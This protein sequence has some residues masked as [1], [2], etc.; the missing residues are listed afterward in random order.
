MPEYLAPGVYV[1]EIETRP[2][3]IPGV[4][5]SLDDAA[6]TSIAGD[7]RRTMDANAP[8]W[9]D[10]N[11]SDP[12]VTLLEVFAFLSQ[13]LL[14]RAD[15]IP[16]RGRVAARRAAEVLVT[17]GVAAKDGCDGLTRPRYFQ[18]QVLDAATLTAEQDYHREKRRIHNREVVGFGIVSG[19]GVSVESTGSPG[20][21]RILVEPGHAIDRLGE[22]IRLPCGVALA[23]PVSGDSVF[24][25]L[26]YW[27]RPC[28]PTP[29]LDGG[30]VPSKT[31]EACV[32]GLKPS[33][34]D[35][36]VA[37]ARLIRDEG[38]WRVDPTS[39]PPRIRRT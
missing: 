28:S 3:P 2:H 6:L 20:G 1:E 26:R 29:T 22:E 5:T 8:G 11:E 9:T 17:L 15:E 35:P 33:V 16:E 10:F 7:F 30:T 39:A 38:R 36:A 27:E 23:V 34:V 18:G 13:S 19:L 12:G 21:N 4:S 14:Y 25:T 32:L 31:E 37:L 24:V